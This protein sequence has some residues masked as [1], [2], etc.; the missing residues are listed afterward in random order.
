MH[1]GLSPSSYRRLVGRLLYLTSTRPDL[2][3]AI[4]QL[5]QFLDKPTS[6]HQQAANHVLRYI[7]SY[8]ANG[9]FF[10]AESSLSLKAFSDSDWVGCSDTRKSI[11]GSCVFL[12]SSLISWRA[13]KQSIVS[14]SSFEAEYRALASTTCEIQWIHYLL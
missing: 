4:Q 14:R 9:L 11:T 8:P 3:F 5:N 7:K 10:P 6:V 13:K 12:G 1:A 2:S